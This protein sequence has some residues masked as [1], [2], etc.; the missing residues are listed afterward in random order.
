MVKLYG[1]I[2]DPIAQSMSPVMQNQE[3][4]Q[5]GIDAHYQP[6]HILGKDLKEAVVGMKVSGVEGFN[7]TSPH[8]TAIM[9]LLDSIPSACE[10]NRSCE[11]GC[12]KNGGFHQDTIQTVRNILRLFKLIGKKIF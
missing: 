12:S 11:Y 4:Q 5:L 6:F 9:P 10:S 3:F 8:K 7:V 1:V 2:G